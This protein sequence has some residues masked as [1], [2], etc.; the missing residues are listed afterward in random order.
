MGKPFLGYATIKVFAIFSTHYK[1][2]PALYMCGTILV[3]ILEIN[4]E[5]RHEKIFLLPDDLERL[6]LRQLA[7]VMP[8]CS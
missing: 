8:N 7:G 2:S 1:H 4:F 3:L 5:F 6:R